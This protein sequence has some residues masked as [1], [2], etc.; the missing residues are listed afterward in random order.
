MSLGKYRGYSLRNRIFWGFL[1]VCAMC[2]TASSLVPY[3]ILKNNALQQSKTD[4]QNKT[5]AVK[6]FF[7]YALSDKYATSSDIKNVLGNKIYEIA[8]INKHDIVIYD[9]RGNFLLTN[10]ER[11]QQKFP[12]VPEKI[13]KD[14]E[15]NDS[16]IDIKSYDEEKGATLTSSY[17]VLKNNVLEPIGIVYIPLYH[18]EDSYLS[19]LNKYLTYIIL[20]DF[21][22]LM[23][24]IWLS[25]YISKNLTRTL[26]K[27]SNLIT[28]ITLFEN[29]LQPIRYYQNDELNE[30]VKA[31][32][33]MI[34]QIQDQKF[35]ISHKER[36]EAWKEMAKQVAH[37]VKNPL[38]PMKLTIQNF[39]RKFDPEDPNIREK[40]NNMSKTIVDQIDLI[41]TVATA[42]SEFAKLPERHDE[43]L[44]L[45]TEIDSIARVF[46]NGNIFI[47]TNKKDIMIN[48]DKIYLSRIFTN[49]ITNAQQA[50]SDVRQLRIDIDIEQLQKRIII[51]VRDNGIGISKDMYEKI[52]EPNF[53]SKNS[54]MGLGLTMVRKMIEEYKG[55][56]TLQSEVGRGTNFIIT[57]PTN[58]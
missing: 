28:K 45:N 41:A 46:N 53:T 55:E 21:V 56:I 22:I 40:V 58:L 29:N 13:I 9:L 7:D 35:R 24:S 49:L 50:E 6:Y 18:D 20:I 57:L 51:N 5:N 27:F 12:K 42:F 52:F 19:V 1:V 11:K 17:F 10:N 34:V 15:H 47:H 38:T 4:M 31:Y 39:E 2:I 3:F 37:E 23:L 32:N 25:W 16:R 14:L 36:D 26:T 8:D 33:K 43:T 48:M 30:L 44:N 54:G